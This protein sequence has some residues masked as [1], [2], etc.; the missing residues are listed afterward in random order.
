[1][2][3]ALISAAGTEPDS[4]IITVPRGRQ[5]SHVC[6][7]LIGFW[8]FCGTGILTEDF[9]VAKQ[10]LYHS[11]HT[12]SPLCFAYFGDGS[13]TSYLPRLAS[14]LEPLHLSPPSSWDYRREPPTPSSITHI[15]P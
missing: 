5:M 12:S 15:L 6:T 1:V 4:A 13:L 8:F 10:V 2:K 7:L 11:S 3:E 9:T 14:N